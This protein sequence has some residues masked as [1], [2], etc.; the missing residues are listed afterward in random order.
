MINTSEPIHS[1]MI[2]ED[3]K[4]L[5]LTWT[6]LMHPGTYIGTIGVNFA[7][8]IGVYCFKRL[9]IRS[10]TPRHQTYFHISLQHA[11][12]DD[13]VEVVPIYRCGGKVEKSDKTPQE[14]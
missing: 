9:W 8:C 1:F 3:D 4:D 6:I 11:T 2:K 14:S 7:V 10:A 12:V 5:S 13:D